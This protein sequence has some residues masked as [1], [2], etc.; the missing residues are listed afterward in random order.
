MVKL[1][2]LLPSES[3]KKIWKI[4]ESIWMIILKFWNDFYLN[5]NILSILD[6]LPFD[7]MYGI[8]I[9]FTWNLMGNKN[10]SEKQNE[11]LWINE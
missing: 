6:P 5:L 11:S 10:L 8:R 4:L 2:Q 1:V 9:L 3:V 7:Y